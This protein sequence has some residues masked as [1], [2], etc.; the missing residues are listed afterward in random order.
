MSAVSPLASPLFSVNAVSATTSFSTASPNLDLFRGS[1]A[2]RVRCAQRRFV[3]I[4]ASHFFLFVLDIRGEGDRIDGMYFPA[5]D[6]AL[7]Q[8][9]RRD[10]VG[11]DAGAVD[12]DVDPARSELADHPLDGEVAVPGDSL[13]ATS[14]DSDVAMGRDG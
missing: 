1:L 10:P 2:A 13:Y 4:N 6:D 8:R 5:R 14:V 12:G 11:D 7:A 9:V 3:Q